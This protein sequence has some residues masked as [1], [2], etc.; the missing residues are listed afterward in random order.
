[1]TIEKNFEN[2]ETISIDIVCDTDVR[3]LV[4]S[5]IKRKRAKRDDVE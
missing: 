1:M 2:K 4:V 5:P 3:H